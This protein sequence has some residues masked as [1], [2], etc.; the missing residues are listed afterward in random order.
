MTSPS[1][2]RLVSI[3]DLVPGNVACVDAESLQYEFVNRTFA[4]SFG[5]PRDKIVGSHIR[6]IIGEANYQFALPHIARVKAGE[7]VS[8]ENVF[9]LASGQRWIKVNYSPMHDE[10]GRVA[11]IVVLSNDITERK[12]AERELQEGKDRLAL[13]AGSVQLGI[14]DWD[15]VNNRMVWDDQ[16]YRLYGITKDTAAS[17]IE[18][19]QNGLHPD[20]AAYAWEECQAAMR[21]GKRYDIEFRVR[22]PDGTVRFIKADGIVLRDEAGKAVRM[23]GANHDITERKRAEAELRQSVALIETAVDNLPLIFYMIDHEGIFRLSVGAGLKGLG[24]KQ[25]QVCGLSALEIYKD[26]PII[27]QSIRKA[28]AGETVTFESHVG[29]SVHANICVPFRASGKGFSGLVAV[30]LDI[31]ESKKAEEDLKQSEY[32]FRRATESAPFPIMLHAENG[33][34]LA[35]SQGWTDSSGYTLVDIPTTA[36][37]SERAYGAR[38]QIVQEEIDSLYGLEQ[39]KDDGEYLVTCKD[40]TTRNWDFSSAPM[41]RLLDG[42]RAVISMAKDVTGRRRMEEELQKAQRL[43]SLGVLAGGIAHDFNNLMGGVFGYIELALQDCRDPTV[44]RYLSK[45]M[46]ALDRARALTQQLLT[47]A[48]GGVPILNVGPLF[49]FVQDT[50]QFALSGSSVACLLDVQP[51]LWA[52]SFDKNQIGQVIDNLVINAQ[53][54]MPLGGTIELSARNLTLATGDYPSLEKGDYVRLSVKDHGIGISKE[55]VSK[56]FDPFFTTKAMGHGLGLATCYSIVHRHGGAIDVESEP[57]QGSTFHVYLPASPQAAASSV[58][59]AA[60]M[61]QGSGTFLVMDDEEV[62]RETLSD[63][64]KS[65]GYHV[66]CKANGQDAVDFFA[67]E[68]HAQRGLAGMIFD[69]TVPGGMGGI[70]AL[71]EIR[72]LDAMTPAFVASGYADDPAVR[73]P[74]DYGFSGSICKPFRKVELS[75][76]LEKCSCFPDREI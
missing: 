50:A 6:N 13:A 7:S 62:I 1:L 71:A 34:V 76:I 20:D 12:Q 41:G 3:L 59:A 60:R 22:H 73:N 56:I 9:A 52:C 31:T 57:G 63:M 5:L 16:M 38:K 51:G 53:Q 44:A 67:A 19:W 27:T 18:L 11:S 40:G 42:R 39:R 45:T 47:F 8:Y 14:W 29:S 33:E 15:I 25:N 36:D 68:L 24:L 64:L 55:L 26:F 46:N 4:A 54:A 66:V 10:D 49:P 35:I 2:A 23:L 61:H 37:W 70:A 30:A 69:L 43:E 17:G 58:A 65:F 28:L 75:K 21:G 74:K 48:K 72:K 32:R